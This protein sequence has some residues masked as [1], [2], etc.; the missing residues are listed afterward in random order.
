MFS[1]VVCAMWRHRYALLACVCALCP[2]ASKSLDENVA[3]QVS[4]GVGGGKAGQ[5]GVEEM[6]QVQSWDKA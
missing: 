4:R 1:R 5:L 3:T 2:V 6:C